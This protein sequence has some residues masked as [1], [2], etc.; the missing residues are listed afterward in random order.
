MSIQ[1][2]AARL[3]P[4]VFHEFVTAHREEIIKR[5]GARVTAREKPS[6]A[7][8]PSASSVSD[9]LGEMIDARVLAVTGDDAASKRFFPL[10]NLRRQL[11]LSDVVAAYADLCHVVRELTQNAGFAA[12]PN[13]AR[14]LDLYL[15]AV[16]AQAL[17]ELVP[18]T[19]EPKRLEQF[20]LERAGF[21]AH[22]L[23]NL[24]NTAM[25]AMQALRQSHTESQGG[26]WTVLARSLEGLN[27]LVARSLDT[28][29]TRRA[30]LAPG[31]VRLSEL[32]AHIATAATLEATAKGVTLSVGSIDPDV[33]V[34]ADRDVLGAVVNNL[35]QN[36]FK[37]TRPN[38]I[39]TLR[40]DANDQKVCLHVQ[41]EC[42]GLPGG[43]VHALFHSFE[44][45][46]PD[47]TGLGLGLA[48]CRWGTEANNGRIY[49][50]DIA[51]VG[52]VFT[53]ELPRVRGAAALMAPFHGQELCG[54]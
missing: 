29:R 19:D 7:L 43:D 42:G 25:L 20:E 13:D 54:Q 16:I 9:L 31:L 2:P 8:A 53:V 35:L 12:T 32:V 11:P 47:R 27:T 21:R 14:D 30:T 26:A 15:D 48:F 37:F 3:E 46:S 45:L 38:S 36:A 50:R 41:D 10:T 23:R 49:V 22:E 40:V 39:V 51:G 44:Q 6:L 24:L 18:P 28:V 17:I 52:C 1:G 34:E 33:A 4:S 5:T